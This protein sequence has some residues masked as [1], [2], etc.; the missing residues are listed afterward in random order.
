MLRAMQRALTSADVTMLIS[1]RVARPETYMLI[2]E[3]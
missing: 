3:E 1:I 2:F